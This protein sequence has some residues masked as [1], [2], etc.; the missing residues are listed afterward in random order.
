[1]K[2]IP[3]LCKHDN[4]DTIFSLVLDDSL[5][6]YSSKEDAEHFFHA[7]RQKYTITVDREAK[8]YIGINLKL[9]YI[10]RTVE[11]SIP[12]YVKHALHKFQ[13]LLPSLPEHS[14]YAHNLLDEVTVAGR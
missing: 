1:M 11:L 9:D 6:Q 5:V 2:C 13:Q 8:E 14:P 12:E 7:L 3:G 10:K 4:K